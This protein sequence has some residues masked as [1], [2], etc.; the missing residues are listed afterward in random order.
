MIINW[1]EIEGLHVISKLSEILGKWFSIDIFFSDKEHEFTFLKA[2][3]L[4]KNNFVKLLLD[5]ESASKIIFESLSI[6]AQKAQEDYNVTKK[7]P[8]T[9]EYYPSTSYS[10]L[11]IPVIIENEFQGC[12]HFVGFFENMITDSEIAYFHS[13]QSSFSLAHFKEIILKTKI[14]DEQSYEY[15]QQLCLL[16]VNEIQFYSTQKNAS[17]E[18]ILQLHQELG[19]RFRFHNMIGKS[20]GMQKIYKILDKISSSDSSVLIQGENGT[21]KE[22]VARAIHYSSKRKDSVF[23]AVNCSAFNENLLDSELFGH[24]KGSFTG[25]LRDKR[26]LF[27]TAHGGTLFLDEIG[28]TSLSMQVKLLRVLQEG[29]F[30]PVGGTTAKKVDVRIVAATNRNLKEMMIKGEF[31]EDLYYRICVMQINLPPLRDRREDIPTLIDHFLIKKIQENGSSSKSMSPACLEKL[32]DYQWPGNVRELQNE[33]ERLVVLSGETQTI[34]AEYLSSK[35]LEFFQERKNEKFSTEYSKYSSDSN[36][37]LQGI[38]TKGKMKDALE[39]L[40]KI[41]IAEGLKRCNFNKSKLAKELDISRASLIMK[42]EKYD[43]DK[44]GKSAS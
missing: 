25:A 4:Y 26:G 16:F 11:T 43:L 30:I 44:R 29:T 31:R 12:L 35:I 17:E 21:G 36:L 24:L 5:E 8:I 42:V 39:A 2:K 40:E 6:C 13:L 28:D 18:K 27:E 33:I 37:I 20:E 3:H 7:S 10:F 32:L 23:L 14:M 22:L 19:E 41:M 9:K 15:F 34:G 38:Q 1:A